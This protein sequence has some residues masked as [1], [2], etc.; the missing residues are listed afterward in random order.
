MI[1][2]HEKTKQFHLYNQEMSYIIKVLRNGSIGQ[3]YFGKRVED[4]PDY[5]EYIEYAARYMTSY[6]Y[7]GDWEFSLEHIKQE[8]P[9]FGTTDY[10]I[11]AF[12]IQ[13][14]NGSC[15]SDFQYKSHKIYSGK[16]GIEGLPACYANQES[17]CDSLEII[18]EDVVSK[19]Q[20]TLHY[21]IFNELN[22]IT[23]RVTFENRGDQ[24][25]SINK[26]MSLNLDLPDKDYEMLQFSGAWS[27]ERHVKSRALVWG[28]Q[29]FGSNRGISSANH[30]PAF[31]LSRKE[32]TESFGEAIGFALLYSGNFEAQIEVST[33]D[34]TRV[35]LGIHPDTFS[36]RLKEGEVFESPEC[37]MTY[38]A[39]GLQDISNGFHSLFRHYLIRG[40]WKEKVRPIPINNWEATYF[41]F[42]EE[43]LFTLAKTAKEV[44][45][46]LFVLDDGWFGKRNSELGGLGDWFVNK[47]KIPIGL[48]GLSKK[49][50]ELGMA[51]GIWIEP[52][53]ISKD[54]E[55][56]KNHP[57]WVLRT[58][59]RKTSHGRNQYVLDFANP[60]VV[61]GI[62]DMLHESFRGCEISYIK[63]DMNRS[64]TECYSPVFPP[65]Q[66][67]EIYH[68]YMLGVYRLYERM[69]QA[70]PNVLFES[71]ASGGARFD[72]GMLYYAPQTWTSDDNDAFERVKIQY[73]TSFIYPLC[74][75]GAHVSKSP[76][77]QLN[78]EIKLK[79]RGDVACFGTFGYELDLGILSDTERLEIKE[80]VRFMKEYREVIQK[81]RFYR[82]QSP[83][84][85]NISGWMC[86]DEGKETAVIG[87]YRELNEVN[88]PFRRIYPRG[89]DEKAVYKRKDNQKTYSGLELMN[90]GISLADGSCGLPVRGDE[91]G[92][93]FYS[94]LIVLEKE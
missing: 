80:Q 9:S 13:Q 65:E 84:E 42:N 2:F 47:E 49:I 64:L 53:M 63:W 86:V 57:E 8:Y 22:G 78:R 23:R 21:S 77:A 91:P 56:Y 62:F 18:L 35:Q 82:L 27:R 45:M 25:V 19:I 55:L 87:I 75:M 72:P 7:E 73:G 90:M 43:K 69:I 10:R 17:D 16:K 71:C 31:I 20:M 26:I 14:E 59:E 33:H 94:K 1:R 5:S 76:N 38:S 83:F 93:D 44:G 66:Q 52:E 54:S 30:N 61:E 51:F 92:Y 60:E 58:P 81:G 32:T 48:Q 34:L 70:F 68:R 88:A 37:A 79:T 29:G 3:I 89:L 74:T 4:K 67:G 36:W 24:S 40:S 12:E 41:D 28:T 85:N 46:E 39:K 11:P 50:T 6:V 15:I